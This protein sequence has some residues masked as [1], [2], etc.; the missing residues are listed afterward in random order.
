M[1]TIPTYFDSSRPVDLHPE[2]QRGFSVQA[3]PD[4][5]GASVARGLQQV[6][7]GMDKAGADIAAAQALDDLNVTKDRD[8]QLSAWTRNAMYGENGYMLLE[9]KNAVDA[10]A[11]FE[12]QLQDKADELGKG[13]SPG[14]AARYKEAS[15]ARVNST[16]TSVVE[17]TASQRKQWFSDTSNARMDA[18]A[19]DALA[20][21]G[22]TAQVNAKLQGGINELKH[23]AEMHGWSDDVFNEKKNAYVSGVTKN[24]VL[25]MAANDPIAA[26]KYMTDAG[27]RLSEA[28]RFDLQQKL[29]PELQEAQGQKEAADIMSGGRKVAD[30]PGDIVGEVA[31]AGGNK[32][33][34]AGPTRA[35][36]FLKTRLT[37][38]HT[39]DS[40]D[41]LDATF[42]TNLAAMIEDAP[43]GIREHLGLFS[44]FR[45]PERQAQIISENAAKYG[46]DRKAWESDVASM[47]PI[48]AGQKWAPKFKASGMSKS[49]GKPGGSNHQEGEAVDLGYRGLSLAHAP[50]EVVDWV[51]S[52]ANKYNLWFP[53][54]NENWHIE[55]FGSRA[56]GPQITGQV[57]S[58][59]NQTGAQTT[60]PSYDDIESRLSSIADP[61]VADIAR[62][63]I[64]AAMEAQNKA[65]EAAQ[66]QAQAQLWS[67]IDQGKTPDDVPMEIRQAAG[68]ASVSSAW[69]YL[70]TVQNGR[71]VTTD[72]VLFY[73]MQRFAATN[74]EEFSKI[75]VLD[76]SDRISKADVA[77]LTGSQT[78]WLSDQQ[79]HN[80]DALDLTSAWSQAQTQLQGAGLIK[81]PS[82]MQ[83]KDKQ[84]LATFQNTLAAKM[85][86]FKQKTG[87]NPNQVETQEIINNLLLPLI[88]YHRGDWS[89]TDAFQFERYSQPE[90]TEIQPVPYNSIPVQYRSKL[91]NYLTVK[92][93]RVPNAKE[94]ESAYLASLNDG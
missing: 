1:P 27:G 25:K 61:K 56:N 34:S 55:P 22:D 75:N 58:R 7:A 30:L 6:S 20:V 41:N 78:T 14:A 70:Q 43:P 62:R 19:N 94:V 52:N 66:K 13:L 12:K 18:F 5:F 24:I 81:T 86:A 71:D 38:G 29:K 90:G 15:Q 77:K 73:Q 3:D 33:G 74:P 36:Q 79:K 37:A 88:V 87:K 53:L 40:I 72:P 65:Q 85:E 59:S 82:N 35:R 67:Y 69:S 23:Q 63:R 46:I 68:M 31:A 50:K 57:R 83:E 21:Y 2:F 32:L 17:H 39:P 8:N 92:L 80:A 91:V 26:D 42:A 49:I 4:A 54:A 9:G 10:R 44:G 76:Y 84:R 93:K 16:L 45:S 47:G 64:Y 89:N 51:H 48:A 28:D 11:G 60:M